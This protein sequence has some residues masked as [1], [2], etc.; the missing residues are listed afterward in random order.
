[1]KKGNI[2]LVPFP[3]TDLSGNKY[4]PALILNVG[5]DDVTVAFITT[6][7]YS[8]INTDIFIESTKENGLKK[9]SLIRLSKLATIDK[10]LITGRLG[11]LDKTIISQVNS[12][13][14]LVFQLDTV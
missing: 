11:E 6:Q 7:L 10:S 5:E 4:R 2:I 3:F 14:K 13:L 9:D 8:K 1:M 12:T